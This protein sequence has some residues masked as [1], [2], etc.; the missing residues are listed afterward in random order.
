MRPSRSIPVIFVGSVTLLAAIAVLEGCRAPAPQRSRSQETAAWRAPP[1]PLPAPVRAVWVAR[2]HYYLE[3]DIRTILDNCTRL[4]INT[5]LW[6]V[7]GNGTVA[8]PSRLEP[9]SAEF[10]HRDPGFDPLA[11]AVREAHARDLHIQAYVNVMPGWRGTKPPPRDLDPPQLWHA[12]PDWFLRDASG[13]RQPLNS[14]YVCLN[15]CLP[16]VRRHVAAVVAEIATRYD[17]DGIHLD[18]IRYVWDPAQKEAARYPRDAATL[19]L[20]RHEAGRHPD[21]DPDAWDAWRARQLTRLVGE[22]RQTLDR[23]R[24]GAA[25]T[26]A[27]WRDPATA[28]H[29]YLQ[30]AAGWRRL[31]LVDALMPMAYSTNLGKLEADIGAYH[32]V[33][34]PR[35]V[36][37]G[38]GLYMH[39]QPRDTY[40]QLRRCL[41]WGGDF[42]LFSYESLCA[43]HGDR[44][45]RNR[46]E[47]QALRRE[48]RAIM[49]ELLGR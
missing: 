43:T 8:Y 24:P 10:G 7:R 40:D 15:P 42:A 19:A 38:I 27:V 21:D 20:Y 34:G 3:E 47:L 44:K 17:I 29:E 14:S 4:G 48:R 13:A 49:A 41:E 12:H 25:L 33:V 1:R 5:V 18:Y 28:Y 23:C 11:V 6:Q 32:A 26:A 22:L 45:R 16:A 37:P 46:D 31:G 35:G 9:W 36:V 2:Y 39:E 30:N